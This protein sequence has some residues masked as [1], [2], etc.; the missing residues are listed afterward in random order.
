MVTSISLDLL[1]FTVKYSEPSNNN[2]L[3]KPTESLTAIFPD[4]QGINTLSKIFNS[5]NKL[6]ISNLPNFD[7][8]DMSF[9]LNCVGSFI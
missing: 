1:I 2:L 8:I 3:D 7:I 6:D 5:T 9:I 4:I